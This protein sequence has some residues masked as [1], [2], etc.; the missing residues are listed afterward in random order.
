MVSEL[1]YNQIFQWALLKNHI[2]L[3]DWFKTQENFDSSS[4][5]SSNSSNSKNDIDFKS[6]WTW[7]A[8]NGQFEL[9]KWLQKHK[10]TEYTDDVMNNASFRGKTKIIEYLYIQRYTRKKL[11]ELIDNAEKN[12]RFLT[13]GIVLM[14]LNGY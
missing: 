9:I 2:D 14:H 6:I 12:K 1:N 8:W 7:A 5:N 13:L 3:V 11:H 10:P 4:S